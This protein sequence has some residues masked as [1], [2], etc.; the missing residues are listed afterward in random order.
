ML[1]AVRL[2]GGHSSH[3][4]RLE[5]NYNGVWGTV[6]DDFF[7]DAAATV[8]CR[9]LGFTYVLYAWEFVIASLLGFYLHVTTDDCACG[10]MLRPLHRH[11]EALGSIP[12]QDGTWFVKNSSSGAFSPLICGE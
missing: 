8:V 3:E 2:V 7:D 9:S 6:C 1:F 12:D 5:V 11:A 4:G 10:V